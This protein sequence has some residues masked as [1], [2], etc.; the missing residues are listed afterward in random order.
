MDKELIDLIPH[1]E[2]LASAD[3]VYSILKQH[4]FYNS[5]TTNQPNMHHIN[6]NYINAANASLNH[7]QTTN[8]NLGTSLYIL[9]QQQQ[10]QQHNLIQQQQQQQ[11]QHHDYEDNLNQQ[12]PSSIIYQQQQ[13]TI[14]ITSNNNPISSVS[15]S[16]NS[17]NEA[18]TIPI[19]NI[20]FNDNKILLSIDLMMASKQQQLQQQQQFDAQ[21]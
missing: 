4:S 2:R 19:S 6:S 18:N 7:N 11:Q 5:P 13:Q 1:F 3:S 15:N 8:P 10:Q 21:N 12:V 9:Q 16:A 14:S 17:A 20:L